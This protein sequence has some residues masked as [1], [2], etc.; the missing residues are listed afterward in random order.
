MKHKEENGETLTPV[1]LDRRERNRSKVRRSYY[2]KIVRGVHARSRW[3][4]SSCISHVCVLQYNLNEL[5]AQVDVLEDEYERILVEQE[6]RAALLLDAMA[7]EAQALEATPS[8]QQRLL[9]LARVR[10]SLYKENEDL[11]G[12]QMDHDKAHGSL[13]HLVDV[14]L[15]DGGISNSNGSRKRITTDLDD[16]SIHQASDVTILR[17]FTIE[18]CLEVIREA[19]ARINAYSDAQRLKPTGARTVLGWT[20]RRCI[21]DGMLSFCF[22]KTLAN[23]RQHE[24]G[25]ATWALM[26]TP[27]E[28]VQLY[29]PYLNVRYSVLQRLDANNLVIYR[30]FDQTDLDVVQKSLFLMTRF[31]TESGEILLTHA[32]DPSRVVDNSLDLSMIGKRELWQDVF[33]W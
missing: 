23:R 18:E 13:Q 16:L 9:Q 25:D 20:D 11:R 28:L 12:L 2:R 21:D 22:Q 33:S 31:E 8:R 5:R 26:T 1:E 7:S 30:T 19:Y 15:Q 32:L 4:S 27:K 17:K 14:Q 3:L 6:Q 29:S 24:I 10:K